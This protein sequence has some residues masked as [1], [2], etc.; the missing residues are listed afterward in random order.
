MRPLPA[1]LLADLALAALLAAWWVLEAE[2]LDGVGVAALALMT[3]PLAWRR[4][5]PLSALALVAAGFVLGATPADPPEPLAG[6]VAILVA[7]YSGAAYAADRT[8]AAAAGAVALGAGVAEGL[9][10]GEDLAFVLLLIGAAWGAGTVV[11]R[12]TGRSAEL[13]VRAT[14]AA[15]EE[16]ERIAR[17]LHDVVSHSVSLMVVQAGAAEQ[18]LRRDPVQAERALQALQSTG[19]SAVDDLRRM[20]GLLRGADEHPLAPQPG[21]DRLDELVAAHGDPV[22]LERDA[23]SPLPP[24]LDLTAY[25]IVQEALTNARKH[26]SGSRTS[27]RVAEAGGRLA[28]EVRTRLVNGADGTPSTG[29]GLAGMR[30]RAAL[31]GGELTAGR[32]GGDWVV[33]ASLPT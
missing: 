32:E 28:I 30:E 20:L 27:V 6:L 9:V 31:Y 1:P 22:E 10:A 8:R 17:E 29:H 2:D 7:P 25:R 19:R 12:L 5:A 4:V 23:A 33:R 15:A 16:R 14:T 3:V 13:E 24:G 11:R 26:A 21:L 18:V